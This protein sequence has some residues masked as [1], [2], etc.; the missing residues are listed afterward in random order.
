[1][2]GFVNQSLE[3]GATT[4]RLVFISESLWN[5]PTGF[6][7]RETVVFT[8]A[9]QLEEIFKSRSRARNSR[10]T[11]AADSHVPVSCPANSYVTLE[12]ALP[13]RHPQRR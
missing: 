2:Q 12:R 13:R 5:I 1:M 11:A 6:R 9:D 7:A 8:G 10:S 4:G 3:P